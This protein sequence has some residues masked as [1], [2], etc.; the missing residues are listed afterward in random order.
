VQ[1]RNQKIVEESPCPSISDRARK[2]LQQSAVRL[3][4]AIGY[5]NAGTV[6]FIVDRDDSFYFIEVNARIQVEHPISEMITGIDL[7]KEQL[8]VASGEKLRV[9]QDQIKVN[10]HSIECRINA[11]DPDDNFRPSPGRV[12]SWIPAGGAGVRVDSHV[13]AGYSVPPL[14]DSLLG[15]LIV[16]KETRGEA[17]ATM[18]RALD[19]FV[20]EGIKTNLP[21]HRR[22][23]RNAAF[24]AGRYNTGFL[25]TYLLKG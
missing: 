25:D 17:I 23:I 6:E 10:G 22:I 18:R 12:T 21:L 7:V 20:V 14:Y 16:H 8:K 24:V 5:Q 2:K 3:A 1:R 9:T 15:K 4:K 19:E 11:E 13:Y